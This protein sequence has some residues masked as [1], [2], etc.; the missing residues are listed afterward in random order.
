MDNEITPATYPAE[1][2]VSAEELRD[3]K[4]YCTDPEHE[5]EKIYTDEWPPRDA[6]GNVFPIFFTVDD[7]NDRGELTDSNY[8]GFSPWA[9]NLEPYSEDY[10]RC[11]TPLNNWRERYPDVR[12]CGKIIE[13]Y[14]KDVDFCNVH[15]NRRHI[16]MQTAEEVLQ[17]GLHTKTLD[18]YYEKVEAWKKLFGWGTY[19]S[20]MGQSSYDFGIEYEPRQFDFS[21]QSVQPHGADE[22][23][24]LEVKCGYPTQHLDP[25]MSLFAAAMMGVQMITVQPRIMHENRDDGEGMMES[26][27]V[28]TAQ[29]T[30]PPSEHDPS[31]Q[32]FKTLETWSEHHLNLPLSR[33]VSDRERLLEM[34]GVS[35]DPDGDSDEISGDD[36]VVEIEA[37]GDTINTTDEPSDPNGFED[38]A[39]TEEL[40]DKI[41]DG[42]TS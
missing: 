17:T 41:N 9:G 23:G 8:N 42:E 16:T 20:L 13:N 14:N 21:E 34:G 36:I 39:I 31:P 28:E 7:F 15:K 27:S 12:F 19:E 32:E 40:T 35:T 11:N 1:C 10:E 30:A 24:I 2:T 22:D 33:L 6:A 37:E 26:K 29:L 18:H 25:S 3:V 38:Q 5:G 4:E